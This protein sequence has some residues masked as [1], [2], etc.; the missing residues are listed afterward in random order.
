M[1]LRPRVAAS[2]LGLNK[3]LIMAPLNWGVNSYGDNMLGFCF[4][5]YRIKDIEELPSQ[6]ERVACTLQSIKNPDQSFFK[7]IRYTSYECQKC[8]NI[9]REKDEY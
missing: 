1:K 2:L 4:H 9:K 5:S 7:R 8:G 6:Y 3:V